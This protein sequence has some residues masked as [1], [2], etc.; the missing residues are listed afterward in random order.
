VENM[1]RVNRT[2][3]TLLLLFHNGSKKRKHVQP[4]KMNRLTGKYRYRTIGKGGVSIST[5]YNLKLI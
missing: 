2:K 3:Y 5:E 1:C 4:D